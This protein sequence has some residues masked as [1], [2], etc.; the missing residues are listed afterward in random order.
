M[1]KTLLVE[2]RLARI[3]LVTPTLVYSIRRAAYE[4]KP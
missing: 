1:P 2:I 3:F 4:S